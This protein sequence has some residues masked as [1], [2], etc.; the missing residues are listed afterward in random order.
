MNCMRIGFAILL[1]DKSHNVARKIELELCDKFGLCYGLKQSPHITIKAPFDTTNISP[2]VNYFEL[3]AKKTKPFDIELEGFNY[4]EPN[5]I[6]LD[7]KENKKLKKMHDKIIKEMEEKFSIEPHEFEGDNIK[8]H[9][10]LAV[11][12]VTKSKFIKAKEYLK[13]YKPKLKFKAKTIGV[14]YYLGEDAGWAIVK[15]ISLK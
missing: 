11:V 3:V 6:F 7:V 2:F 10:T 5:V 13:K 14:F 8:F 9:V 15:R 4:F 1:D 12:D